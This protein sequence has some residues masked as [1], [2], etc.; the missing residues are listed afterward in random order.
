MVL[1]YPRSY[2]KKFKFVIEIDGFAA[3]GFEKCSELSVEVAK[4]E[5]Y[6]GGALI[7]QK[8]PGRLSFADVTLQRGATSDLDAYRWMSDVAH[9]ASGLGLVEPHFKRNLDIVQQDRDGRTL[10]RWTLHGAWPVKFSAGDWDNDADENR[11]ESLTL[12]YDF[13]ELDE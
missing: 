6:E 2:H 5:H 11:I 9:L 3:A 10:Q 8:S 4:V 13:F 7:P 12:T 1:G